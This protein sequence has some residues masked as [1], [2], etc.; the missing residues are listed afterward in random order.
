[1]LPKSNFNNIRGPGN[2]GTGL[3]VSVNS[4]ARSVSGQLLRLSVPSNRRRNYD[5]NEDMDSPLIASMD[6]STAARGMTVSVSMH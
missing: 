6:R 1:M 3:S 5:Q 2:N 4:S